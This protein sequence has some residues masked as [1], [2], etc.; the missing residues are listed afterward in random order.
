MPAAHSP[1]AH[2][3]STA[4]RG[5]APQLKIF[6]NLANSPSV[7]SVTMFTDAFAPSRPS[8][9]RSSS[10]VEKGCGGSGLATL[11][12]GSNFRGN[13]LGIYDMELRRQRH[14]PEAY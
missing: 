11:N 2:V 4:A 1:V 3:P 7:F 6:L 10:T 12:M 14:W 9:A 8:L 13:G 5:D